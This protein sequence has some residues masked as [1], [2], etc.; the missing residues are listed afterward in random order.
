MVTANLCRTLDRAPARQPRAC[1]A[2][3]IANGR[4][5]AKAAGAP[6]TFAVVSSGVKMAGADQPRGA[7]VRR[8]LPEPTATVIVDLARNFIMA[9]LGRRLTADDLV[10]ATGVSE[11]TLRRALHAQGGETLSQFMLAIRLDQA[12]AWLATNRESRTQGE[13][14]AALGFRSASA[15]GRAYRRR[16]GETMS[17]TRICAVRAEEVSPDQQKYSPHGRMNPSK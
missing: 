6:P 12:R 15:F 5:A 10:G 3:A 16:F 17:Q 14:A 1:L 4:A 8:P 13:I 11:S 7:K 9:H 2:P